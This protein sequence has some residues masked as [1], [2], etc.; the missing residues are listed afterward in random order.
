M[1]FNRIMNGRWQCPLCKA[2]VK[3]V[4]LIV[5]EIN[6]NAACVCKRCKLEK[7]DTL[8]I[9]VNLEEKNDS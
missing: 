1:T 8:I 9:E 3:P 5:F 2:W 4:D 6:G 7:I